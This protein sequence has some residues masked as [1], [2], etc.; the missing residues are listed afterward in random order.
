MAGAATSI[1]FGQKFCCGK[2]IFVATNEVFVMT[3]MIFVAVPANDRE[4]V[5]TNT[6]EP[7]SLYQ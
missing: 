2:H 4:P 1:V 7:S 6:A 3:K 5:Q